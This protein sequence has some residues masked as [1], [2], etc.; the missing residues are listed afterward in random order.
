MKLLNHNF[1]AL[2][3]LIFSS[4]IFSSTSA[5][6]KSVPMSEHKFELLGNADSHP[7]LGLLAST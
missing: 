7:G 1:F 3:T 4:L 6:E 5:T 2:L